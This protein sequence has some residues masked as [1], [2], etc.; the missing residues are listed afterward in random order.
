M[1]KES[2]S[3][4][5]P[6]IITELL[7]K[8][9]A[10]KSQSAVAR[11]TGLTLLTVQQYLKGLGEPRQKNLERLADYFDVTVDSLRGDK[12][13]SL[14]STF[15]LL[16][17]YFAFI[18]SLDKSTDMRNHGL[19]FTNIWFRR[20]AQYLSTA[21]RFCKEDQKPIIESYLT[22]CEILRIE[23]LEWAKKTGGLLGDWCP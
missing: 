7:K 5:T 19:L 21:Y 2:S 4:K 12:P 17:M 13:I 8:A 9:V 3:R 15:K 10:E 6:I 20:N 16:D 1:V 11:E 18:E 14:S 22:K 23:E